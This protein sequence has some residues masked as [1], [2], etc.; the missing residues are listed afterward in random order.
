MA[1]P[2][3]DEITATFQQL[4]WLPSKQTV[5]A[6]FKTMEKFV[7]AAFTCDKVTSINEAR[8]EMFSS[9]ANNN[10]R[11]L[12]LTENALRM[13]IL[14]S[15][16][17]SGWVWGNSLSQK[18]PT[19]VTQWGWVMVP[20]QN[21][22]HI[23]WQDINNDSNNVSLA[24]IVKTCSCRSTKATCTNCMCGKNGFKCLKYCN[25]KRMCLTRQE[26][27]TMI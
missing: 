8:Y 15:A 14:R 10:L 1:Y 18:L 26:A 9:S 7:T 16:Y 3:R 5:D 11:D 19:P 17:Q 20:E 4:S 2:A 13:H 25:C 12:P 22:L 23:K 27:A 24:T 21:R 6:S